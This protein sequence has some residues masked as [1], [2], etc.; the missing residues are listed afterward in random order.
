MSLRPPQT[1]GARQTTLTQLGDTVTDQPDS[2]AARRAL[3]D[4]L[5]LWSDDAGALRAYDGALRLAPRDP[6]LLTG[7]GLSVARLGRLAAAD[8]AYGAALDA[9]PRQWA[10]LIAADCEPDT[11]SPEREVGLQPRP[12]CKDSMSEQSSRDLPRARS[13]QPWKHSLESTRPRWL[14]VN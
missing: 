12:S 9:H 1:K 4:F 3:A 13:T 7:R 11:G 14:G 6:C 2:L 10:C 5:S 8:A